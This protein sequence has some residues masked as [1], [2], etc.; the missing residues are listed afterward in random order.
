MTDRTP[1]TAAGRTLLADIRELAGAFHQVGSLRD[2]ADPNDKTGWNVHGIETCEDPY[3]MD[4]LTADAAIL[5]IEAEARAPLDV[6]RLRKLAAEVLDCCGVE[7]TWGAGQCAA[8]D[9]LRAALEEPTPERYTDTEY[10][11]AFHD[12]EVA[13]R[14]SISEEPTT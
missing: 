5:A 8:H 14:R 4:A 9:D 10:E 6:E 13:E 2:H 3:C 1:S 7:E 12:R 11:Q